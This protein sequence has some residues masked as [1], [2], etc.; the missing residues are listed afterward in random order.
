MLV[1]EFKLSGKQKQYDLIDEA[2][3]TALFIRNSCIR[4]WL[5][6]R[7]KGKYEFSAYCKFL[8]NNFEWA[9]KLNSMARQASADK[10]WASV[11]RFFDNCKKDKP[12]KKGF[13]K[14]KKRGHSV[15]YKTTGWSLTYDR[16]YLTLTDGF[17]IGRLKLIGTYDLP[18]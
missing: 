17:K 13:P 4:Y 8:A 9:K 6:E 12:G 18:R 7:G 16:N 10:A 15:E 3:R 5:D 2:I 1:Y 11:A 14:F